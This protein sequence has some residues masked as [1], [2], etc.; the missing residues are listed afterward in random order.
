MTEWQPIETAPRDGTEFL[1]YDIQAKK[2]DVCHWSK[3]F[4]WFEAVQSDG[5]TGPWFGEFGRDREDITHWQPLPAPPT[6]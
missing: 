3:N 5:E 2:Q 6:T 4:E 1:A